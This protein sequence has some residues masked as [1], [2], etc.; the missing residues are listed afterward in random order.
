MRHGL[1]PVLAVLVFAAGPGASCSR[2][3]P[4]GPDH[5]AARWSTP[6][7]AEQAVIHLPDA[8]DGWAASEPQRVHDRETI[9]D[10]IDGLAEVYLAYGMTRCV[11]RRYGRPNPPGDLVADVFELA[12]PED[13]FGVFTVD[14]DG[15][16]VP[17]GGDA[18]Y[19]HGW[20]SFWTDRY[21][22]SVVAQ[23]DPG[24]IREP[25]L[26]LGRIIAGAL[27]G[28]AGRPA[29]VGELPPRDLDPRSV[30]FLRHPQILNTHVFV[31]DG[32]PL[33]LAPDTAAALGRYERSGGRGHLLLVD[34]PDA[35]RAAA[36]AGRFQADVL[37]GAA[38]DGAATLGDRGAFAVRSTGRRVAAVLGATTPAFARELL[39]AAP[40]PVGGTP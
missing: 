7:P 9:Y 23:G 31:S 14:R 1:V 18:L 37:G 13:A 26:A 25:V 34:Y 27:P 11:S 36:A 29:L 40:A 24:G 20:L 10:Y 38:G 32:N 35:G 33:G 8:V 2:S 4:D 12:S 3:Q 16:P 15:E 5:R 19:R 17:I 6:G 30:R 39:A 21:F 28:G 22:V